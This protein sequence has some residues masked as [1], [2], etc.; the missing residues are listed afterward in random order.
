MSAAPIVY[1]RERAAEL[2]I[3][4]EAIIKF[5]PQ[6]VGN[7]PRALPCALALGLCEIHEAPLVAEV[8]ARELG[9]AIEA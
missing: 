2:A 8:L 5:E 4:R 3:P 7:R 6:R 9:M 1:D